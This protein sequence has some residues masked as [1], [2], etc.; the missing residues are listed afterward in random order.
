MT[1]LDYPLFANQST[2]LPGQDRVQH[3]HL[4][5][6]KKIGCSKHD[7]HKKGKGQHVAA[8]EFKYGHITIA[9][10]RGLPGDQSLKN[11]L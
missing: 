11:E 2:E 3:A 7:K 9:C 5:Y 1:I 10:T 4:Q 8:R 6:T